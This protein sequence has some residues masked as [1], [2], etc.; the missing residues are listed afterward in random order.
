[1][2]VPIS[3]RDCA[4]LA[5]IAKWVG[6]TPDMVASVIVARGLAR[7]ISKSIAARKALMKGDRR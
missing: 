4:Y 5:M 2:K 6:T 3:Q 1:M 7:D